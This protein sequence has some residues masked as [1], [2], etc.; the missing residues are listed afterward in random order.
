MAALRVTRFAPAFLRRTLHSS[1]RLAFPIGSNMHDN[2][3][4]VSARITP[5]RSAMTFRQVIDKEK[6][7]VLNRTSKSPHPTN[8]PGWNETLASDSEAI[9]K[10]DQAPSSSPA[11]LQKETVEHIKDVH[12]VCALDWCRPTLTVALGLVFG[13]RQ[14]QDRRGKVV[15]RGIVACSQS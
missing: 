10:A 5:R 7:K 9:L 3:P 2:D 4:S 1:P 8:A 11:E 14:G 13:S 12:H 6:A 15:V